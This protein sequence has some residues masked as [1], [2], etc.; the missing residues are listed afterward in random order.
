MTEVLYSDEVINSYVSFK[1]KTSDHKFIF[2]Y[3]G[4][5]SHNIVKNLLSMAE[6]KIDELNE[7]ASLKRK[8]FGVMVNCLQ[9]ICAEDKNLESPEESI[10]LISR[11]EK[12]FT[13]FTGRYLQKEVS[14]KLVQVIEKINLLS[15]DSLI[16]LH[17]EKLVELDNLKD[18]NKIDETT[19]S[20]IDISKKANREIKYLTKPISDN[21]NFFSI[22]VNID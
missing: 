12:E 17:K 9:T 8:I 15:R 11:N 22:Q 6:K 2:T 7:L 14:E 3:R 10:F 4:K 5:I 20:L 1:E 21:S 13:V 18:E 16:D 19:L